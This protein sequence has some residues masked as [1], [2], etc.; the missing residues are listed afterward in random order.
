M[1][2]KNKNRV[3]IFLQDTVHEVGAAQKPNLPSEG[4]KRPVEE[5]VSSASTFKKTKSNINTGETLNR[6]TELEAERND[7]DKEFLET[8]KSQS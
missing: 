6:L 4:L 2:K 5:N 3:R 8:R 7:R 1:F